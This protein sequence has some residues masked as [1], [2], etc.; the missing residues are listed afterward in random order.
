MAGLRQLVNFCESIGKI[1]F[2]VPGRLSLGI[3]E[4]K[5]I[6]WSYSLPVSDQA[7]GTYVIAVID[8]EMVIAESNENNNEIAGGPIL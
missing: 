2:A 3:H 6:K 8:E 5:V 1:P 7:T 4:L